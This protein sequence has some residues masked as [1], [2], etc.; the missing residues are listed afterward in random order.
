MRG[1]FVGIEM[2]YSYL[3]ASIGFKRAAR[4]AGSHEASVATRSKRRETLQ[5]VSGS[6]GLTAYKTF[7]SKR[8]KQMA[9]TNPTNIP[10]PAS[11]SPRITISESTLEPVAPKARR[12]PISRVKLAGI[13]MLVGLV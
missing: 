11:F 5:K 6:V 2:R 8:F 12:K 1:R 13:G 7:S 10:I 9:P 4:A 3:S